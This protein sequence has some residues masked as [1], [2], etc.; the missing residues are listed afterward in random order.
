MLMENQTRKLISAKSV[1]NTESAKSPKSSLSSTSSLLFWQIEYDYTPIHMY[2]I[3]D[4]KSW[5]C[6]DSCFLKPV[7]Q[8]LLKNF[9]KIY[10]IKSVLMG[11]NAIVCHPGVNAL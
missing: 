5:K 11:K 7:F 3:S 10:K 8:S 4:N 1:T 6:S 2:I 9:N